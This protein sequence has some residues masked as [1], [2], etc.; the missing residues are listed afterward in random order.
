MSVLCL[1]GGGVVARIAATAFTLAWMHTVERIPWE[2]DWR[3]EGDRLVVVESRVKGS[4]AGMD[5]PPEARLLDGFYRWTPEQG[6]RRE[7][8]LRRSPA[9]NVGDWT[10]CALGTCRKLGEILPPD[11]DPVRLYPCE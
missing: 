9:P 1:A 6:E 8:I 5:P 10:L 2:E 4:G 3:V 7:V 11:A